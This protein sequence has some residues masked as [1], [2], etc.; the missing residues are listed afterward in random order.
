MALTKQ[1]KT[2]A[3]KFGIGT[4]AYKHPLYYVFMQNQVADNHLGF[5]VLWQFK[6]NH[7]EIKTIM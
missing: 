5:Q 1:P 7:Q 6:K 4:D 3:T 2:E